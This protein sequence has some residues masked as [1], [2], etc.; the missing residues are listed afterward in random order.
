MPGKIVGQ[1]ID[2]NNQKGYVLTLSTREQHIRREHAT[3]N[4][5]TN[6][7]LMALTFTIAIS[8]YGKYRFYDLAIQNI[9]RTIF[10][11]NEA[12]K[13]GLNIKFN[14]AHF[15]ESVIELSSKDHLTHILHKLH[16]FQILYVLAI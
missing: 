15:N 13:S 2:Q 7:N 3:S 14:T 1:T 12:K 10:F 9:K 5:C 16:T 4:I 6:H 11:R 8:L